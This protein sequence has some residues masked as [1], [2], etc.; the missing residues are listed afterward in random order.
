MTDLEFAI[1]WLQ[2]CRANVRGIVRGFGE[3][4]VYDTET[5]AEAC[6]GCR[7][8]LISGWLEYRAAVDLFLRS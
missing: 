6:G 7:A 8:C 3:H 4:Y 2:S 5:G 1:H